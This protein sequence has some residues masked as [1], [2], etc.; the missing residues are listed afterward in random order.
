VP[1]R[2]PVD[3]P[4]VRLWHRRC[5]PA[6]Q[7]ETTMEAA[8]IDLTALI[9]P[10]GVACVGIAG[11]GFAALFTVDLWSGPRSASSLTFEIQRPAM[12]AHGVRPLVRSRFAA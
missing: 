7:E 11:I 10:F 8:I 12:P 3:F 4:A 5:S 6:R 9:I 1:T 2:H